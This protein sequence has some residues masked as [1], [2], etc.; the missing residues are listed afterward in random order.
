MTGS[1]Q[2]AHWSPPPSS[3]CLSP[4]APTPSRSPSA[5]IQ[6]DAE[7]PE[8]AELRPRT[9]DFSQSQGQEGEGPDGAGPAPLSL[10]GSTAEEDFS[11]EF[12]DPHAADLL[13]VLHVLYYFATAVFSKLKGAALFL[14]HF[15]MRGSVRTPWP[16]AS[17]GE[18]QFLDSDSKGDP[19][20]DKSSGGP[21][22][23]SDSEDE[24]DSEPADESSGTDD[25][26]VDGGANGNYDEDEELSRVSGN[27]LDQ[28]HRGDG[29]VEVDAAFTKCVMQVASFLTPLFVKRWYVELCF[30]YAQHRHNRLFHVPEKQKRK[31]NKFRISLVVVP[32]LF[33]LSCGC[34]LPLMMRDGGSDLLR[35]GFDLLH[36]LSLPAHVTHR[37]QRSTV[38]A[39]AASSAL[40]K[41]GAQFLADVVAALFEDS[42]AAA[43]REVL[44]QMHQKKAV[45][46]YDEAKAWNLY[47][48]YFY[49]N[50]DLYKDTAFFELL[51]RG[52]GQ[53]GG[54]G[55][56]ESPNQRTTWRDAHTGGPS[57]PALF[58]GLER[59]PSRVF[60]YFAG[61]RVGKHR[62]KVIQTG[63]DNKYPVKPSAYFQNFQVMAPVFS[64]AG[65]LEKPAELFRNPYI[66]VY[67]KTPDES[68]QFIWSFC[69][70]KNAAGTPNCPDPLPTIHLPPGPVKTHHV[71]HVINVVGTALDAF[72]QPDAHYFVTEPSSGAA[73]AFLTR[74]KQAEFEKRYLMMYYY[75]LSA[76]V[77]K[78]LTTLYMVTIG[79]ASFGTLL[80]AEYKRNEPGHPDPAF[81]NAFQRRTFWRLLR[82]MTEEGLD[83]GSSLYNPWLAEQVARG[84]FEVK[85]WK[86]NGSS[87]D[88]CE[89]DPKGTKM[90][91]KGLPAGKRNI[92]AWLTQ[93]ELDR[94]LFVNAW[95]PLSNIGNGNFNDNSA[96][97]WFGQVM[98]LVPLGSPIVNPHAQVRRLPVGPFLGGITSSSETRT[99]AE[100]TIDERVP[101]FFY[102]RDAPFLPVEESELRSFVEQTNG[103][104]DAFRARF[105]NLAVPTDRADEN[106]SRFL[107]AT[108][109]ERILSLIANKFSTG[110][111][112]TDNTAG[113]RPF[114]VNG[115]KFVLW[116]MNKE[117]YTSASVRADKLPAELGWAAG[118]IPML[119]QELGPFQH[120]LHTEKI[121]INVVPKS[122]KAFV[123]IG[124]DREA[125]P[126][127][128]LLQENNFALFYAL[129][130]IL[131]QLE[132]GAFYPPAREVVG[133]TGGRHTVARGAHLKFP[134]EPG[135]T[136]DEDA[137][138]KKRPL[139]LRIPFDRLKAQLKAASGMTEAKIDEQWQKA[140]GVA[141]PKAADE[142]R[143][144]GDGTLGKGLLLRGQLL[145]L[146]TEFMAWFQVGRIGGASGTDLQPHDVP[147][148]VDREP[149]A[150]EVGKPML[151]IIL[152]GSAEFFGLEPMKGKLEMRL[153]SVT[154]P[155]AKP[156]PG[157]ETDYSY[158]QTDGAL[159]RAWA[160]EEGRAVVLEPHSLRAKFW[161]AV[162]KEFN[163]AAIEGLTNIHAPDGGKTV[164][165]NTLQRGVQVMP[166]LHLA[167]LGD[168]LRKCAAEDTAGVDHEAVNDVGDYIRGRA[169]RLN[170]K[171]KGEKGDD[172]G[173]LLR[174]FVDTLTSSF[175]DKVGTTFTTI[176]NPPPFL[177]AVNEFG[178]VD[179]V[180]KS[181]EHWPAAL[182]TAKTSAKA[183]ALKLGGRDM[184]GAESLLWRRALFGLGALLFEVY[185]QERPGGGQYTKKHVFGRYLPDAL[186]KLLLQLPVEALKR[187]G[188][189]VN[190]NLTLKDVDES[191]H[192]TN[193]GA[194]LAS[195]NPHFWQAAF[196]V[197][198]ETAKGVRGAHWGEL[199]SLLEKYYA[200]TPSG[201]TKAPSRAEKL[202]LLRNWDR[203]NVPS[204]ANEEPA[205]R[206][207]LSNALSS[208]FSSS[209]VA[210]RLSK[211]GTLYFPV[212]RAETKQRE[213][214]YNYLGPAVVTDIGDS[215]PAAAL[216]DKYAEVAA[217]GAAQAAITNALQ[218]AG[219]NNAFAATD[220]DEDATYCVDVTEEFPEDEI[221]K[222]VDVVVWEQTC[223][224]NR[225]DKIINL[226]SDDDFWNFS[227]AEMEKKRKLL[228]LLPGFQ[229][230]PGVLLLL[231]G[232]V[233]V[234]T[235]GARSNMEKSR[236]SWSKHFA[237]KHGF[238]VTGVGQR[239]QQHDWE[240]LSRMLQGP[241]TVDGARIAAAIKFEGGA[242]S[243]PAQIAQYVQK[244]FRVTREAWVENADGER[245][246]YPQGPPSQKQLRAFLK[247][248]TGSG[249][250]VEGLSLTFGK[251]RENTEPDVTWATVDPEACTCGGRLAWTRFPLTD[252]KEWT[253]SKK[254]VDAVKAKYPNQPRGT[255]VETNSVTDEKTFLPPGAGLLR[256]G[257]EK[258]FMRGFALYLA[259]D[260]VPLEELFKF[261][262]S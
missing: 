86:P 144:S 139:L 93:T 150:N 156:E 256:A 159:R 11:D 130:D 222:H 131:Y 166:H 179:D 201:Q 217:A 57:A 55:P 83:D 205:N 246:L 34:V 118:T 65:A 152:Q 75:I 192:E 46:A 6:S 19:V 52:T 244:W 133:G 54:R 102:R 138:G 145:Q 236:D 186:F 48:E 82:R 154:L 239:D 206:L 174:S 221:R 212:T 70:N 255:L 223:K 30:Q 114:T 140:F 240:Q 20:F 232:F 94:S 252:A 119:L 36:S 243:T 100:S 135:Q 24:I 262:T 157:D 169:C 168:S 88:R 228:S 116:F 31:K 249:A 251:K 257:T 105:V 211:D 216:A 92:W 41:A 63:R 128:V 260:L 247:F 188:P 191:P 137:S 8:F 77:E 1:T 141:F 89:L 59:N 237:G 167:L 210:G 85:W 199:A 74:S 27:L 44:Q 180:H 26:D 87:W 153:N 162:L 195:D 226:L 56:G 143:T 134:L 230:V 21:V 115:K 117:P 214:F 218:Y 197:T 204:D 108:L 4:S 259:G 25:D 98:A 248:A 120:S 104:V 69:K 96:D 122:G 50:L 35:S 39:S 164:F 64:K 149:T 67:V 175:F 202:W 124:G 225:D 176:A 110:A 2:P 182:P 160:F 45:T 14:F 238:G 253:S 178:V 231:S 190:E 229:S 261:N 91:E 79:T 72:Y 241:P 183:L 28:E 196:A 106:S 181:P 49:A 71:A 177:A 171:F 80:P 13:D 161:Q 235:R 254:V 123:T 37:H 95:D 47:R 220:A 68:I 15:H 60:D 224:G 125:K 136:E 99:L 18:T 33:L 81:G 129:C 142:T 7:V 111:A 53:T 203:G 43:S 148:M 146:L 185:S 200:E 84:T 151:R 172:A 163:F 234:Q 42:G 194:K 78:K 245:D 193:V 258:G 10:F 3:C 76:V 17:T 215:S 109:G 208:A 73:Q 170:V 209:K 242:Y 126:V 213:T 189:V 132:G 58:G 113:N 233:T 38:G 12:Q 107:A 32:L 250:L 22:F 155:F 112:P 165:V 62:H 66:A 29:V 127:Q 158:K 90:K 23:D 16:T 198:A 184:G 121:G 97:G 61:V 103:D 40:G 147:P 207:P 9:L 101:G 227:S 5:P 173:G 51:R 187:G 219:G